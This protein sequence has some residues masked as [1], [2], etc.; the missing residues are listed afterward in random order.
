M[1]LFYQILLHF[2][3]CARRG[4]VQVRQEDQRTGDISHQA[5]A[6]KPAY[7]AAAAVFPDVVQVTWQIVF[8]SAVPLLTSQ[9]SDLLFPQDAEPGWSLDTI[10]EAGQIF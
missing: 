9:F 10:S 5:P 7:N 1:I 4:Q 3:Y 6:Q 8:I 2:L